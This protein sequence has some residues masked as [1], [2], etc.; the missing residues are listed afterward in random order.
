MTAT[1][2]TT[3][4]AAT[5]EAIHQK[6]KRLSVLLMMSTNATGS[7]HP[8]SC[9]SAAENPGNSNSRLELNPAGVCVG[10]SAVAICFG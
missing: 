9:M 8:T 5:L 3:P 2:A 4:S 7:G 10:D 6:A 1:T